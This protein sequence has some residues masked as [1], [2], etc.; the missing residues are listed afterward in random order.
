MRH[1]NDASAHSAVMGEKR[2]ALVGDLE[3]KF[4]VVH[5]KLKMSKRRG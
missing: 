2:V 1:L 3:R 4:V 5:A